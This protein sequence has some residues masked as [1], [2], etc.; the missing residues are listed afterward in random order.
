MSRTVPAL[1]VSGFLGSG[2]TTLVRRILD[3][4]QDRGVRVALVSNE[5]GELGI[6]AALLDGRVGP[7]TFRPEAIARPG[8][9]ALIGRIAAD[10]YDPGPDVTD[11]SPEHPDTV[12]VALAGGPVLADFLHLG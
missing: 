11:M 6:D 7:E 1:V 2:K 4:A 3:D 9:A 5:F 10:P 12:T 8:I